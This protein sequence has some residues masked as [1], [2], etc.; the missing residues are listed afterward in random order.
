[1]IDQGAH[2]A[3]LIERYEMKF[4]IP[5]EKVDAIRDEARK[6]CL[7][8]PANR[9]GRY[10]ICSL[11]FDTAGRRFY[12]ETADRCPRRFKLRVRRYR[13]GDSFFL[14]IKRRIKDVIVKS[15]ARIDKAVWPAIFHDP[16]IVPQL[17]LPQSVARDVNAYISLCLRH[18][19]APAAL[20]RYQRE[21]YVSQIDDYARVT[22]DYQLEAAPPDGWQIPVLDG[23]RWRPMDTP[24]RFGLGGSGVVLELK[25]TSAVPD[26]MVHLARKFGLKRTGF[27]KFGAAVE[28]TDPMALVRPWSPRVP[29]R[30]AGWAR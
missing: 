7:P 15:R 14:E 16:R 6:Y 9:G 19:A 5:F 28:T 20:V 17:D 23:P 2:P 27:S 3:A 25:C 24:S 1:M 18:S 4:R 11:Y 13:D 8:D 12:R 21:A 30:W 26:W 29:G 22:F 10:T